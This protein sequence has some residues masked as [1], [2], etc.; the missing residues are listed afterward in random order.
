MQVAEENN[1]S[2]VKAFYHWNM[3][4]SPCPQIH[5]VPDLTFSVPIFQ[6]LLILIKGSFFDF[7]KSPLWGHAGRLHLP[8]LILN[9]CF[10]TLQ[11][12]FAKRKLLRAPPGHTS[13]FFWGIG[14]TSQLLEPHSCRF[15]YGMAGL[16]QVYTWIMDFFFFRLLPALNSEALSNST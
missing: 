2:L 11:S 9:V 15:I 6:L 14:M 12:A 13:A 3:Q 16:W 10:W 4:L 7:M 5:T 1:C 8:E